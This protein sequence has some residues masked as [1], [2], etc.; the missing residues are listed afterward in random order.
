MLHLLW[1]LSSVSLRKQCQAHHAG[2]DPRIHHYYR[3]AWLEHY[4]Q[5][6]RRLI[7]GTKGESA[8]YAASWR[9]YL[10]GI[11]RLFKKKKP[12]RKN[13]FGRT[14]IQLALLRN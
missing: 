3:L 13:R 9:Y 2:K 6:S 1:L 12:A 14:T 11:Y 7:A 10:A 8:L 5:H 4:W